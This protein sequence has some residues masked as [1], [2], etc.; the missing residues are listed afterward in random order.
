LN[1][2][3]AISQGFPLLLGF[4]RDSHRTTPAISGMPLCLFSAPFTYRLKSNRGPC[5]NPTMF[6]LMTVLAESDAVRYLISQFR[7]FAPFLDMVGMYRSSCAAL[8]AGEIIALKNGGTPLFVFVAA[9]FLRIG[10]LRCFISTARAAILRFLV[11]SPLLKLSPTVGAYPNRGRVDNPI[12]FIGTVDVR[13]IGYFNNKINPADG[14]SFRP[15]GVAEHPGWLATY[16]RLTTLIACIHGLIIP[17]VQRVSTSFCILQR[18]TDAFP[19]IE[20]KKIK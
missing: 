7:V 20:I 19:G 4:Y 10:N 2:I 8:L 3:S 9:M 5:D 11:P 14:T 15:A 13:R 12:T 16:K 6:H 1:R 18:M 17:F